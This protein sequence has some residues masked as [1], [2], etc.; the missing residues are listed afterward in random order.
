MHMY[1]CHLAYQQTT[2]HRGQMQLNGSFYRY[3]LHQ[4]CQDPSPYLWSTPEQFRATTA[5][6]EDKPIFQEE[7]RP[8]DAQGAAQGDGGRAKEDEDMADLVDYFMG[9]N[10]ASQ[11]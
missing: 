8:V 3:T 2:N 4:H 7:A 9:G 10:G 5:W 6:P 11:P 1:M